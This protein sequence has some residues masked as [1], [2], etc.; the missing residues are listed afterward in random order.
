MWERYYLNYIM[1]L[2]IILVKEKQISNKTVSK[3]TD[4][5]EIAIF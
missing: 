5:K 1:T 3:G 4:A 2:S